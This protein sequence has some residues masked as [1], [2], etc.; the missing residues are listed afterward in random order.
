MNSL[1]SEKVKKCGG[2][3]KRKGGKNTN[4]NNILNNKNKLSKVNNSKTAARFSCV[5]LSSL[6]CLDTVDGDLNDI[7]EMLLFIFVP[8][9]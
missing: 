1:K 2:S 9:L 8:L 3:K 6:L 5:I 4:I 7:P